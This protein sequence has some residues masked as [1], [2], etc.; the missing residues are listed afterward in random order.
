MA[1]SKR[2]QA[3]A[4]RDVNR[5]TFIEEWPETGLVVFNSPFDPNP[6]IKVRDGRI[7]ELDGTPEAR[8]DM[9]DR[10]IARHAIDVS[11]AEAAMA[12]DS[13]ALARM[14]VDIHSPRADVVRLFAG[15]TP[16]PSPSMAPSRLSATATTLPGRKRSSLRP[17]PPAASRSA[18]PP[19]AVRRP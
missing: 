8:F 3:R 19:A 4:R 2:F 10:F 9:L 15:L 14:L 1:V 16:K 6:Q 13:K 5:D 17:T 12:T 18:S 7:I 11:V